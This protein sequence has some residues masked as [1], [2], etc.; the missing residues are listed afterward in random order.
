MLKASL[1]SLIFLFFNF[2]PSND[3]WL[4]F[5]SHEGAFSISAPGKIKEVIKKAETGLGSLE[6]H[7]F[8]HRNNDP[9]AE[10]MVYMIS[11]C[12]YPEHTVHSDSTELLNLFFDASIEESV[13]SVNGKLAYSSTLDFNGH[14]GRIWRTDYG[15]G[16]GIIRTK[17]FMKGRRYYSI[18]TIC[19]LENSMNL[20]S[21]KFFNSFRILEKKEKEK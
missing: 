19:T 5:K 12:D 3:P 2:F 8:I 20:S 13:L 21:D 16:Q 18:Q 10:N 7:V 15:N 14:P 1:L 4:E 9:N 6:Y 11:Y 17:A